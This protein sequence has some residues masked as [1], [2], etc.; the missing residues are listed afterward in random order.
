MDMK[1]ETAFLLVPSDPKLAGLAC[2]V[3]EYRS[4]EAAEDAQDEYAG[5]GLFYD[6][7]AAA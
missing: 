5:R 4:L 3:E 2:W 7:V 6:V 1:N